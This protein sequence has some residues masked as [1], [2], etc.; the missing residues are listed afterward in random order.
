MLDAKS[1]GHL[2][3]GWVLREVVRQFSTP[4]LLLVPRLVSAGPRATFRLDACLRE[5]L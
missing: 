2:L 3:G 1:R 4:V 5:M